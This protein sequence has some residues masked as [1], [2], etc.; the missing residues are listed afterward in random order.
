MKVHSESKATSREHEFGEETGSGGAATSS[1]FGTD[2]TDS[3]KAK[4]KG[5]D[6][7]NEMDERSK[8]RQTTG[9]IGTLVPTG[10][11]RSI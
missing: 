7:T 11:C 1:A 8:K 5:D 9:V 6:G 4:R 10:A 2:T 3:Q